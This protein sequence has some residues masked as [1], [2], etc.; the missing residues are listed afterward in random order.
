[1]ES[2][3]RWPAT[4]ACQREFAFLKSEKMGLSDVEHV[5]N[6]AITMGKADALKGVYGFDL[7]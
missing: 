2:P 3:G 4:A 1:M 7:F 6:H 5:V